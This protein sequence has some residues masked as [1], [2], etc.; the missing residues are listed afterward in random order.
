MDP[1]TNN[2]I[3]YGQQNPSPGTVYENTHV[4]GEPRY[5]FSEP[6][7]AFMDPEYLKEQRRKQLRRSITKKRIRA[8]GNGIGATLIGYVACGYILPVI[9][10]FLIPEFYDHYSRSA[11]F[12]S[13]YGIFHSVINILVPF[14]IFAFLRKKDDFNA[15]KVLRLPKDKF[16]STLL[17]FAGFFGCLA[18]NYVVSIVQTIA[19]SFGIST[20]YTALTHPK[21]DLDVILVIV[22]TA[23]VPPLIEELAF[24]GIILNSLQKYGNTF[25]IVCSALFF[26][27]M[28]ANPV[29]IPYAFL[30][31]LF[32]GYIT[33]ASGS[34]WPAIAVHAISNGL[35]ATVDAVTYYHS[36]K[37]A[38][39]IYTILFIF[40][41]VIGLVS[42]IL[43]LV[44]YY[45]KD[46][47]LENK[48]SIQPVV[49][50]KT[51]YASILSSPVMIIAFII[52]FKLAWDYLKFDTVF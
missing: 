30:C 16:K 34:L 48:K 14:L 49:T 27:V 25:A 10:V 50:E 43:Y 28:H 37:T 8:L 13:A 11:T 46:D 31:G 24:R 22:S 52:C 35:S 41:I 15:G 6:V 47:V 18:S 32:L 7:G 12:S 21:S 51:K 1:N 19:Q 36:E 33:V 44:N 45:K 2:S 5:H 9:F 39:D 29:Q 17:V 42:L 3:P 23:I 20:E 40:G 38:E 26:G 4:I